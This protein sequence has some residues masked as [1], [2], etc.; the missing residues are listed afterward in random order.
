MKLESK[1]FRFIVIIWVWFLLYLRDVAHCFVDTTS[2]RLKAKNS[3][4]ENHNFKFD[5]KVLALSNGSNSQHNLP[6]ANPKHAPQLAS[7]I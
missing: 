7:S 2:M 4:S 6:F 5:P 3:K 1:V